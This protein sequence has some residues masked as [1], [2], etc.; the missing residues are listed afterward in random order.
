MYKEVCGCYL[1]YFS[2]PDPYICWEGWK[3]DYHHKATHVENILEFFF[4]VYEALTTQALERVVLSAFYSMLV[5]ECS[6]T[7]FEVK[8]GFVRRSWNMRD[9]LWGGKNGRRQ[10][11][12]YLDYNDEGSHTQENTMFYPLK[13]T[14]DHLENE[15]KAYVIYYMGTTQ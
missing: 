7:S 15:R 12:G 9:E 8:M 3:N 10:P 5:L 13:K 4:K 6:W 1:G 11:L 2:S 14:F